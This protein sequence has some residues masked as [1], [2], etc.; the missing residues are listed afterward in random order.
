M[1]TA[2][3]VVV[4]LGLWSIV[5]A[6]QR[7]EIFEFGDLEQR[8][9]GGEAQRKGGVRA[10]NRFMYVAYSLLQGDGGPRATQSTISVAG[11]TRLM[12][13]G[14]ADEIALVKG[15]LEQLREEQ[16]PR[17]RLQCSFLKMPVALVMAHGLTEDAFVPTDETAFGKLVRDAVKEK[18]ALQNLPEVIA[19]PLVPFV[20]ESGTKVVGKPAPAADQAVRVRG[21]MVPVQ[22]GEVAFAMQLV[23]GPVPA[24]RMQV[25]KDALLN[26]AFRLEAGKAV[27]AITVEGEQATVVFVRCTEVTSDAAKEP[28][29]GR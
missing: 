18:G 3:T 20:V 11:K 9:G 22:R 1:G 10:I 12:V 21:E 25:P 4:V 8:F 28:K 6:Q 2:R 7:A 29:A 16:P 14:T 27:M 19:G 17:A 23:R 13:R 15:M 5:P 26:R 24:D